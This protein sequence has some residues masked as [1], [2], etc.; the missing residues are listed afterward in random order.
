VSKAHHHMDESTARAMK[1]TRTSLDSI[2]ETSKFQSQLAEHSGARLDVEIKRVADCVDLTLKVEF[3]T[4][5]RSFDA[6]LD[7]EIK[8]M[9]TSLARKL[10]SHLHFAY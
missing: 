3:N 9:Q 4:M 1:K 6:V 7:G 2:L 5:Q 8:K 10:T